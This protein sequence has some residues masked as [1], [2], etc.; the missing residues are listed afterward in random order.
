MRTK[1]EMSTICRY[2]HAVRIIVLICI[3]SLLSC[4]FLYPFSLPVVCASGAAMY[5]C[6][7]PRSRARTKDCYYLK[8]Q[9]RDVRN[10]FL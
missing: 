4:P 2:D 7:T 10:L 3:Y 6:R 1:H 5:I 9:P 8:V